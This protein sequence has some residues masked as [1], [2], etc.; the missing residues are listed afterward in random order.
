MKTKI[1]RKFIFES[2]HQLNGEIYGRCGNLHGHRYEL[3]IEI[4][5]E[6]NQFGWICDFEE[7]DEIAKG[8]IRKVRS[9]KFEQLL[10]GANR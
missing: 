1:G 10:R 7:L 9:S 3:T 6:V 8:I 5:G 2:A 4:E